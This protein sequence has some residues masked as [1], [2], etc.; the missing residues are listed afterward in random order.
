MAKPAAARGEE[1][2]IE[3][4]IFGFG[5]RARGRAQAREPPLDAAIFRLKQ[6]GSTPSISRRVCNFEKRRNIGCTA[7]RVA[8]QLCNVEMQSFVIQLFRATMCWREGPSR[9]KREA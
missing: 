7:S 9:I 6:H 4:A 8:S 3:E 2:K 5:E 1:P